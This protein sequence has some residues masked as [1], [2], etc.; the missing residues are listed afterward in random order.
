[1]ENKFFKIKKNFSKLYSLLPMI[2]ILLFFD[3]ISKWL[4]RNNFKM[5]ESKQL[6]SFLALTYTTNTG[7]AFGMFEGNNNFFIVSTIIILVMLMI[8]LDTVE[9]DFGKYSVYAVMLII[10]GGIGN[11]L[12]RIFLGRVTDFIDFQINYKNVWPIFNFADSYV[13]IG[14]WVLIISFIHQFLK[15]SK[16]KKL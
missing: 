11:L 14:V 10:S 3:Q 12:D 1:M 2:T 16:V 5:F 4:I 8:F 13:F 7:V 9:Q 6:T 15:S